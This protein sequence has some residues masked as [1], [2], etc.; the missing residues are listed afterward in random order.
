MELSGWFLSNTTGA[1]TVEDYQRFRIPDGIVLAAGGFLVLSEEDFN[2]NGSWNSSGGTATEQEFSLDGFRGGRLWLISAD[3]GSGKLE[4]FQDHAD[5]TP[6][7]PGTSLGCWP[8]GADRLI[9]L[10]G[11]T[12]LGQTGSP[13]VSKGEPNTSPRIGAVQVSEVIYHPAFGEMEYVEI[14]NTASIP[15]SLEQ[16]TLRGDVDYYFS[17]GDLLAPTD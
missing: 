8:D 3:P 16:W 7:I 9:P 14:V 13:L 15:Q 10:N 1:T 6:A 2:P 12:L 4:A 17:P 5:F 11:V